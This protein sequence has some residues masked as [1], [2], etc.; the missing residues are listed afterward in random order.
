MQ[1]KKNLSTVLVVIILIGAFLVLRAAIVG[2]LSNNIKDSDF[3]EDALKATAGCVPPTLTN[4]QVTG[5]ST[6][7][8]T[9]TW[10][11]NQSS[12]SA[13]R[14]GLASNSMSW[15]ATTNT[16]V[17]TL[18]TLNH[19]YA[20]TNLQT[21][22]KYYYRVRSSNEACQKTSSTYSFT[23]LAT[24]AG[25]A[26]ITAPSTPTSFG[27]SSISNTSL[28][29]NWNASTDPSVVDAI[30]SGVKGY[31]VYGPNGACNVNGSAGYCGN[32]LQ[33]TAGTYSLPITGLTAN[34]T[35]SGATGTNAGFTVKAYDNANN[36]SVA[37][38]RLAVTTT[39]GV[40]VDTIS[41]TAPTGLATTGKTTSSVSLSWNAS[42]DN[43]GTVAGYKVY[44]NGSTSAANSALI[45]GTAYTVSGLSAATAYSFTVRA[46]DA[47]GNGSSSSSSLSVTTVANTTT[48][49]SAPTVPSGLSASGITS[50]S[51]TLHW[52]TSTD[53]T[54]TA[55]QIHYDVYGSSLACN[56]N[57]IVGYCGAVTGTTSM[58]ISGLAAGTTY[59]AN[60]GANAGFT[61]QAYDD[62]LHYSLGST[63]FTLST[64]AGADTTAPAISSLQVITTSTTGT[65]TW[66]TNE[67][68]TTSVSYG[69][70]TAY[71]FTATAPLSSTSHTV[72]I[73]GLTSGNT[74]H[75][76]VTS[77]DAAGNIA[78]STDGT[79]TA[80][81]GPVGCANTANPADQRQMW[82]WND[83]GIAVADVVNTSTAASQTFF[84]YVDS[85][86]VTVAYIQ[87]SPGWFT[88]T[89][90]NN[91]K[92]FLNVA[93]DQHCLQIEALSGGS[94]WAA[95]YY[96]SVS[97]PSSTSN[98]WATQVKN[99]N[100]S[101]TGSNAKLLGLQYDVEPYLDSWSNTN[102]AAGRATNIRTINGLIDMLAEAK[103][104][105]AGS[106]LKLD[107][108]PPR[109]YDTQFA[110]VPNVFI[111]RGF[112]TPQNKNAMKYL[113]DVVDI[114]TVQ[115][116]V[117][118]SST[119]Y[120]DG[121]GE[122]TYGSQIGK[123]VRIGVEVGAGYGNGTS[124]ADSPNP[125]CANLNTQLSGAYTLFN[126]A[127]VIG[128]FD[129]FAV[130]YYPTWKMMCNF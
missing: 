13:V 82:V 102:D 62:T 112:T 61:V 19:S 35:Y 92:N 85:H 68:A 73:T 18:G 99:F 64:P 30:T 118:T 110:L 43:S 15:L 40:T 33:T 20:L 104:T 111:R 103:S 63:L 126:N 115:D 91:L 31:E 69:P 96:D 116:Y 21:A 6:N 10:T 44:V 60:T 9:V 84:N 122:V 32:V 90:S 130:E 53:D 72:N 87:M 26:D 3:E 1:N 14:L 4:I 24:S 95:P 5:I 89:N 46:F 100:N 97:A 80:Q 45:T 119:L 11:T 113:M 8:A 71:G 2:Q 37:T 78:T 86:K 93:R 47:A 16:P 121:L 107:L 74:Y 98:T 36:Y 123:K 58:V 124:F 42:T 125:T 76:K 101:I 88:T 120:A 83:G 25:T 81:A 7:S 66:T 39:G 127:G 38:S 105:I 128:G 59:N 52:N 77:A 108:A 55:A 22:K 23:T 114:Y 57:A 29:L 79:F 34:T 28:T 27:A 41:P 94:N 51:F 67:A 106:G 129:G 48:D 50:S 17:A 117:V 75:Y 49:V 109:W 54:L 12:S 70:S 65:V 56:V